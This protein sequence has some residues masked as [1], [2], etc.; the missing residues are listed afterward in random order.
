M[1]KLIVIADDFTGALDTAVQ[2]ASE[3][4]N[5]KV[6]VDSNYQLS[7]INE[8]VEV[9]V[10]NAESRHLSSEEAYLVVYRIVEQAVILGIPNIFKKTDSALRGNIGS[11]LTAVV[12]ASK[13]TVLHFIPAF[14]QMRR[15][16]KNGVHFIDGVPVHESVFGKDP[17]EPVKNSVVSDIIREQSKINLINVFET[18]DVADVKNPT[19]KI[20]DAGTEG[21]LTEIVEGLYVENQPLLIA[22]CAGLAAVL[23]K[24]LS[25]SKG[26][27]KNPIIC[28]SLLVVCG[29]VN[30]IT[31]TQL[32]HAEKN[33]F[34]R[35]HL[36]TE[37]R[38]MDSY[39]E[40][41]GSTK[42]V[43]GWMDI[44]SHNDKCILDS[45][46]PTDGLAD[47]DFIDE[48]K[49]TI[50]DVRMKI[51]TNMGRII[52]RLLQEGLESAIMITG[53]DT[54]MGFI[55]QTDIKEITPIEDVVSGTVL[56]TIEFEGRT[57][58]ILS[59]SGGFGDEKLLI[60]LA[61]RMFANRK[62]IA[63]AR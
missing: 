47:Q 61:E 8:D 35:V 9:L 17:F 39:L 49:L 45:Q 56:F 11:E 31:L 48:N 1:V 51:S 19:I 34:K 42:A 57:I 12:D 27:D 13:K 52:K 59:K 29:S 37:Q 40:T 46:D 20:Y 38:M 50:N 32:E 3:G 26:R 5:T 33:G 25:F 44:F 16:T 4:A 36:T 2:F 23:S 10:I 63:H 21:R 62:E 15:T 43:K 53:G 60:T 7:Q 24:K 6:V 14:P 28:R 55:N 58:Q 41:D 54:L 22:G 18:E 30:P